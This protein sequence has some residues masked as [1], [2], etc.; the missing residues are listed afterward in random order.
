M[1]LSMLNNSAGNTVVLNPAALTELLHS[2]AG[3]VV[4]MLYE[5][6]ERVK[7]AARAQIRVGHVHGGSGRPNLRDTIVK[8]PLPPDHI[9]PGMRVG[10]ESPIALLHHE[11]TRPHTIVPRVKQMLRFTPQGGS[12]FVFAR[13]VEHP[14]TQPNRYLTD[15]LHLAVVP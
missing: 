9:G 8:R 6:G 7:I 10:S 4:R 2:P 5:R 15:N 3:P 14:G 13:R 12:G 11:G 1:A